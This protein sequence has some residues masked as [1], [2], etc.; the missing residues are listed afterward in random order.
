MFVGLPS[1][2]DS[3]LQLLLAFRIDNM[4]SAGDTEI[5]RVKEPEDVHDLAG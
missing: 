2:T 1:A 4:N 5:E 3:E